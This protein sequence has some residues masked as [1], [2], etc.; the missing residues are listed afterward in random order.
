MTAQAGHPYQQN[1]RQRLPMVD[2][3]TLTGLHSS[4]KRGPRRLRWTEI[5]A[6]E[7][8]ILPAAVFRLAEWGRDRAKPGETM[9]Q[10][11]LAS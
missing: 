3:A 4:A 8:G 6:E 11:D 1:W 5:C 7:T 10:T 9:P 2:A